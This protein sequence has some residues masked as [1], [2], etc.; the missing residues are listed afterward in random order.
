MRK[1]FLIYEEM[2]KYFTIYEEAVNHISLCTR[3]LW[4]SFFMRKFLFYFLSVCCAEV[5]LHIFTTISGQ[6]YVRRAKMSRPH[7]FFSVHVLVF[8]IDYGEGDWSPMRAIGAVFPACVTTKVQYSL[9][10]G[11][12]LGQ[13]Q[14]KVLRVFPLLV[15]VTSIALPWYFYF[16]K[17][18]PPLT[19]LTVKLQHNIKEKG[20]KP[21]RKLYPSLWFKNSIRK[22]QVWELSRL[23]QKPEWNCTFMNSASRY[24]VYPCMWTKFCYIDKRYTQRVSERAC[25]LRCICTSPFR[26]GQVC[27][28]TLL[29]AWY[30]VYSAPPLT[31]INIFTVFTVTPNILSPSSPVGQLITHSPYSDNL[32]TSWA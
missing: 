14:T 20:E 21:K 22:P 11:R 5:S 9:N 27:V 25:R 29:V 3:S 23:C 8:S 10:G 32:V 19:V 17:L 30:R 2:R 16:F 28:E 6:F 31:H 1:V 15:T 7:L 24:S 26:G 4:I 18:T 12:I 13:F